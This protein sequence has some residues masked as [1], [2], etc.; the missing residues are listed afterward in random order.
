MTSEAHEAFLHCEALVRT[1]DK[2][3]FLASL[4][5]PEV[6]RRHLH[7]LYAFNLEVARVRAAV[8]EPMAGAIRLQWWREAVEGERAAEAAASP[9]AA[10]IT[11]TLVQTGVA[12]GPLIEII[13]LRRAELFGEPVV[14]VEPQVFLAAARMLGGQGERLP[15]IAADAGLAYDESLDPQ[16]RDAA[17]EHYARFRAAIGEIPSAALPAFLPVALVPLRLKQAQ[18]AQ[19]RRQLALLRAAWLGFPR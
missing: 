19:W 13:E 8:R 18:P 14:S 16:R 9:I 7:A 11:T 12:A 15:A 4:F 3:R 6:H 1:H 17:R 2:D 5:V 10:A